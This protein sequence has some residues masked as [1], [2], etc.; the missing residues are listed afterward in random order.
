MSHESAY[1]RGVSILFKKGVDFIIHSKILHLIGRYVILKAEIKEKMYLLI[2]IYAPNKDTNIVEFLKD[3][4]TTLQKENLDDEENI[5][6]GGDF[7]CPLN[8][9]LDKKGGIL[10]PR[11]SVVATIDC[12]CADFDLVDI[13][14]VTNRSTKSYTWSQNSPMILYRLDHWLIS[15]NLQDLVTT[16][17]IIPAIKT[18]HAAISIKFSI[19]EKHIKGPGH[20]KMNCS[21][22][23]DKDYIRDVTAK[24][25]I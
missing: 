3:L 15:N 6:L 23:D 11:K 10:L 19:S 22:L 2:N 7:N 8:P 4:G 1:S 25:P 18:D 14:R 9:V 13:W 5:I 21:L 16:T 24:I 12:L 20:S 17:D